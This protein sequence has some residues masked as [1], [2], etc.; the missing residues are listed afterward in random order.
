MEKSLK[1]TVIMII[2]KEMERFEYEKYGGIIFEKYFNVEV[3]N[4]SKIF[5]G[6]VVKKDNLYTLQRSVDSIKE[7]AMRLKHYN[8]IKTFLIFFMLPGD[9][10]TFYFGAAAALMGFSYSMTY[11]QP[12]LAKWN[13]GSLKEDLANRKPDYV[14]VILNALFPPTFNFLGTATCYKEFPSIW[15]IKK[16][17]NVLIHTL[18]YD[19]YLKIK[20]ENK[21][22]V[23]EKYILFIDE[24]FVAHASFQVLGVKSA[25]RKAEDYYIPVKA[26]LDQ[27][28]K[29]FGYQVVIAEHPRSNYPDRTIY[30]NRKMIQGQTA[31]LIKD[32]EMVVCHKSLALDYVILFQKK[33]LII[34]LDEFT[35]FY[36]W[37]SYYIPFFH[38]MGIEGLNISKIYDND[39]IKSRI[40]SS[41]SRGCKKYKQYYIKAKGTKEKPFFEIV[42]EYIINWMDG[43]RI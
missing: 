36:Q 12:C 8:R 29:L 41:F 32:A 19:V 40:V 27:I 2:Y 30:G 5:W 34:Y 23:E 14:N 28:E 10:R 25:F 38:F 21:R 9:R 24:N 13:S 39:M 22:L 31:R 17:K 37:E 26:F 1:K 3:W 4:L 15:S 6:N 33:F 35:R 11:P 20:D 43:R 16:Q 7:F 42:A 18:D